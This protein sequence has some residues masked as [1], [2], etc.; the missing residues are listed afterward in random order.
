MNRSADTV[1]SGIPVPRIAGG[2]RRVLSYPGHHL[3]DFCWFRGLD[4]RFHAIGILGTGTWASETS[5]FHVSAASPDGDYQIH[6]PLF[7]EIEQGPTANAAPQKHAPFVVVHDGL[8]HV[9]FRRPKGTNLHLTSHDLKTWSRPDL[10]FEERDARDACI[11]QIDG[12]WHW[13][14]VQVAAV[15]GIDRSCVLLR[16]SVD[17][18]AWDAGRVV[19]ADLGRVATH[20]KLESPYVIV[21]EGWFLLFVRERLREDGR[22]PA[23]ASIWAS[24]RSDHF[25]QEDGPVTKFPDLQAPEIL[26]HDG[27]WW[28]ARISG[29][30]HAC[31][32]RDRDGHGWLEVAVLEFTTAEHLES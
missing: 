16:T 12:V 1:R 6:D 23:P 29:V 2:W 9:W 19:F 14:H 7:P 28:I 4:G 26:E 13:Y 20:A 21:R 32:H 30:S 8:H 10:A 18:L 17:L 11:I 31:A 3:N 22:N 15:D 25:T 27:R 5:L 24:R